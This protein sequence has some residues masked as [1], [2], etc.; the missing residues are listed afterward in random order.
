MFSSMSGTDTLYIPPSVEDFGD[1]AELTASH[2][3]AAFQGI[4]GAIGLLTFSGNTPT[5][6]GGANNGGHLVTT[7]GGGVGPD[8]AGSTPGGGVGP[9]VAGSTPGSGVQDFTG[10]N[11]GAGAG[12]GSSGS[13]PGAAGA[14]AAGAHAA[15]AHTKGKLPFT[16]FGLALEGMVGLATISAGL[17]FRRLTRRQDDASPSGSPRA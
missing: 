14:H 2:H 1:L 3:I 8:V 4:Q 15:T 16:G 9:D 5:G 7:P 6:G 13:G 11:P 12:P 17:A 10:S